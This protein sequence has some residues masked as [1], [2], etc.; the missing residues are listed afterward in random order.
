MQIEKI[1]ERL[2]ERKELLKKREQL[3]ALQHRDALKAIDHAIDMLGDDLDECYEKALA[4][5]I[6]SLP[7]ETKET[8]NALWAEREK[9]EQA[10]LASLSRLRRLA[11]FREL[12]KQCMQL[13]NTK[14]SPLALLFG[15]H[16]KILLAM[17]IAKLT[18]EAKMIS[19]Y[20]FVQE[21]LEEA[22]KPWNR[23]LYDKRLIDFHEA[24]Q[25]LAGSLE[26]E[27]AKA[28]ARVKTLDEALAELI[29][30]G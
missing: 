25:E 15:R 30:R 21:F 6:E 26:S 3:E 13:L 5:R 27:K 9:A 29:K 11:P 4:E 2:K 10:L 19:E 20:P 14:R 22:N 23:E 18:R 24:C 7:H 8:F 12:L 17:Q 28:D 1:E 16:P